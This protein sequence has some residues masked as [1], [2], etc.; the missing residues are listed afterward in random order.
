MAPMLTL[1]QPTERP[2]ALTRQ[3]LERAYKLLRAAL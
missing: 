1:L 2:M 3:T